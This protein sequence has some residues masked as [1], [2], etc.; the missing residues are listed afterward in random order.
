MGKGQKYTPEQREAQRAR[1]RAHYN[2]NPQ[3]YIDKARE[4]DKKLKVENRNNC[5]EYLREHPCV[6]CGNTDIEVLQFDHVGGQ[7]KHFNVAN[8]IRRHSWKRIKEEI[9]KCEVRCANCHTKKTRRQ[10]GWW[11][12]DSTL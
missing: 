1:V 2:A 3:Y 5:V 11:I 7:E 10:F 9:E 8:M 4:R 12:D 6:D